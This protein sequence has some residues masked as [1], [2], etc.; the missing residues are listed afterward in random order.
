VIRIAIT[1]EAFEAITRTLPL[2]S[3][4]HEAAPNAQG[5]RL[6]WLDDRMADRLAAM[7]E[8]GESYSDAILKLA[9]NQ[10]RSA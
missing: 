8:P 1:A 9:T 4:G 6:I 3:V 7:R 5:Q 2:G 10:T